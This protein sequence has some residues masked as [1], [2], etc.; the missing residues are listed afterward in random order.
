[1]SCLERD[2]TWWR[3]P[4]GSQFLQQLFCCHNACLLDKVTVGFCI[5]IVGMKIAVWQL[6]LF[7]VPTDGEMLAA[8]ALGAWVVMARIAGHMCSCWTEPYS[9]CL[10]INNMK[11]CTFHHGT[12]RCSRSIIRAATLE[13][14]SFVMQV[15]SA[16]C[17][18]ILCF[19]E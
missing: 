3:H 5:D 1:M 12:L 9:I 2:I 6:L 7:S 19:F 15:T 14:P 8:H 17:Q 10:S 4:D 13:T 18:Q 11:A 16:C